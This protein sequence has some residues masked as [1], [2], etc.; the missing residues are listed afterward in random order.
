LEGQK[1]DRMAVNS[2]I[3]YLISGEKEQWKA[4]A[5]TVIDFA[6]TIPDNSMNLSLRY[7]QTTDS[8]SRTIT[9]KTPEHGDM[10]VDSKEKETKEFAYGEKYQRV[11][12]Y[13]VSLHT[14]DCCVR[15]VHYR[16]TS[17]FLDPTKESFRWELFFT[18]GE[19]HSLVKVKVGILTWRRLKFRSKVMVVVAKA[20]LPIL[21]VIVILRA[22]WMNPGAKFQTNTETFLRGPIEAQVIHHVKHDR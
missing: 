22:W 17:P 5:K 16:E 1:I 11:G 14:K 8:P 12:Y 6:R 13:K 21:G 4:A 19:P 3:E 9:G 7:T 10:T 18:Y 2:A 15:F 20:I